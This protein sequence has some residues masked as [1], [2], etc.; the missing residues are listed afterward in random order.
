MARL[1]VLRWR[2]IPAEVV[3]ETGRGRNRVSAKVELPKR[4]IAAIDAAAMRGDSHDEEAYLEGWNKA[5]P[6]D[7]GDDLEAEAA[8]FAAKIEADYPA[9]R[10]R[11]LIAN[12]GREA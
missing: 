10:L 5:E 11:D 3:A 6:V 1:V 9:E 2:D 12:G 8:T 4:F 7:C